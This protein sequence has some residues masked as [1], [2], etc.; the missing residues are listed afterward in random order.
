MIPSLPTFPHDALNFKKEIR[1]EMFC[2]KFSLEINQAPPTAG[3][4]PIRLFFVKRS[5]PL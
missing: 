3:K 1:L 5:E 2:I 4:N